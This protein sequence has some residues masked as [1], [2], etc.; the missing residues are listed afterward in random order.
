MLLKIKLQG[1]AKSFGIAALVNR[2]FAQRLTEKNIV[3]QIKVK[4]IKLNRYLEFKDG[5]V[6][7]QQK[8]HASPDVTLSFKTAKIANKMLNLKQDYRFTIHNM[9]NFTVNLEGDDDLTY[10]FMETMLELS[11]VH[12][13]YGEKMPDGTTRYVN[14]NNGGPLNVY[15]KNDKI[16]RITPIEFVDED[17]PTWNIQAR[18]KTFTPPRQTTVPGH[19]LTGKSLVYS[20]DRILYPMKRV[21]FDPNGDR[22]ISNRGK[23][24]YVRISWDE[25]AQLVADE[26]RRVKKQYGPGAL[27]FTHSAHQSMGNV[28]YHLSS[29]FRFFNLVGF[30]KVHGNPQSWEGWYWGAVHHYGHTMRLGQGEVFGQVEDCLKNTDMIVFWSSDPETTNGCYGG[31]EGTIRRM[32]AKELGIEFVHIDPYYNETAALMGGKWIAPRPGTDPALAQAICHVWIK[33]DLYDKWYVENRTTGFEEWSDY[34]LGKT[35]NIEKTPEWAEQETGVP[36]RDIRALARSWGKKKTYLGA[37]GIG[38]TF[39]GACRGATGAQWARMMVILMGMQG[40]GKP[41][42]N[43]GN[44]QCGSPIDFN[45][46]FPG[47]AEG[48]ISGDLQFTA[49]GPITYQQIPHVMTMNNVRQQIPRLQFPEA[50]FEGKADGYPTDVAGIHSQFVPFKYPSPGHSPIR[51][52]YKFGSSQFGTQCNSNRWVKTYQAENIEFVVNQSIWFEGEAKYADIIL[53]ACTSFERWDISEWASAGGYAPQF[54]TQLNHRVLALQHKCIEPLGE[55]KSDYQIFNEIAKKMG[56]SAIYTEGMDELGWC[57]RIWEGSDLSQHISWSD[58]LKKGYYVVPTPPEHLREPTAYSW[59]YEGRKKDVPELQP[60]PADYTDQFLEGLQ[61]IS[62]KFEF[63]PQT[64]KMANDPDRP[65]VNKYIPSWEGSSTTEL[66]EK[67]PL[68]MLAVHP[69]FSFHSQSDAKDS[70]INDIKSHRILIDGHYY[71]Q[72]RINPED[73]AERG[74][75]DGELIRAYNDRGEVV[76]ACKTSPRVRKGLVHTYESSALYEPLGK[77]GE[78]VDIGGSANVLT[79]HRSQ[80]QGG[81]SMSPNSCLVQI[82]PWDGQMKT[83]TCQTNTIAGGRP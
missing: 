41:G 83:E 44:L 42:V 54:Y 26:M 72:M 43:F 21:D 57:Q 45:F 46:W 71:L 5:K 80:I 7:S 28:N 9:K 24:E 32:W 66:L 11:R 67:Y 61:T 6:R 81:S 37:G 8:L 38:N 27:S 75:Q 55:S 2:K 58:F 82:Q 23:S 74:I 77:P 1:L 56:L 39:G 40:Y 17:G 48:G 12:L 65:A 52:M 73:A 79:N 25:A 30:T 62:G 29:A 33:E 69:R 53:P 15:V 16:V 70:T 59:Y 19:A 36:A 47:Y 63:V 34:I 3:V 31:L 18:G 64:L 68:Q 13:S 78:S 49:N 22:N 14:N 60:L 35:D 4:D 76:F 50:V 20:K 10:W 51:M